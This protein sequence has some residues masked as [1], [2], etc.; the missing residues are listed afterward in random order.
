MCARCTRLNLECRWPSAADPSLRD[1]RRGYGSV[2]TR[3]W[4]WVPKK[5]TPAISPQPLVVTGTLAAKDTPTGRD[6][7]GPSTGFW[8]G[9]DE[10]W[11]TIGIDL[12]NVDWTELPNSELDAMS[13]PPTVLGS[14]GTEI[15]DFDEDICPSMSNELP[16]SPNTAIL[17]F[18][19]SR[20]LSDYHF[21]VPNALVLTPFEHQA[22][23]HYSTVFSLYRSTK[24][25]KWSTHKML[26]N[27]GSYDPMIMHLILAVS[28]NDYSIR[29]SNAHA[30]NG[31]QDH[32][33][34]ATSLWIETM[35]RNQNSDHLAL[36]TSFFFLY[37]YMTKRRNTT[38]HRLIK[39]SKSAADFVK[40]HKLDTRCLGSSRSVQDE[41]PDDSS[42]MTIRQRSLLAR[43]IMWTFDEDVKCGFQGS[44]GH[45]AKYLSENDARAKNIYDASRSVLENHWGADYPDYQVFDDNENSVILEF[46]FAMM[47]LQQDI[48]DISSS[49]SS[50]SDEIYRRIQRRFTTLE[51]DY[52]SVFRIA[53]TKTMPR[54][55][56][57]VNADYDVVLFNALRIYYFRSTIID[58]AMDTPSAI[59][60]ALKNLL[61][62]V[63]QTFA[64]NGT[65]LHERLQWPL[66]LAGIET[67]DMIYR[68]WIISKL[69][70][71]RVL[72]A[73]RSTLAAQRRTRKRST[74]TEIRDTLHENEEESMLASQTTFL[75]A[76]PAL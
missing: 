56:V 60:L 4:N 76:I 2:K 29:I 16:D 63:Q 26:L 44:G 22:L 46:L 36:M 25:P 75:D 69:T 10:W 42:A 51:Q 13:P 1:K 48:H 31:A 49:L 39:L 59:C 53:A 71:Y 17:K 43:L 12:E 8:V 33:Q 40:K 41:A 20:S 7:L 9:S 14:C 67:G 24:D 65:E 61:A 74:I 32:F 47:P 70:N 37:L 50:G 19:P 54:T 28:I 62:I 21:T 18:S 27:Y 55:R 57:L 64:S 5:I 34:V 52:S 72:G 30:Y 73:L 35:K 58:L 3:D 6:S 11:Q 23:N 66:F 38:R 45:L 68:E 15:D